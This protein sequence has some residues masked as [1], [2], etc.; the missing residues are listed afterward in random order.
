MYLGLLIMQVGIGMLLS[1]VHI[2]FFTF[3]TFIILKY[4][5]VL[6]EEKYL[7]NKFGKKYHEYKKSVRRWI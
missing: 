6:P 1:I 3:F 4:Y 2:I 5:V 7:E